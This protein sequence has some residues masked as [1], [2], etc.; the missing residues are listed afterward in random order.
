M[1]SGMTIEQLI[2]AVERAERES[3]LL[4]AVTAPVKVTRYEVSPGVVYAMQFAEPAT[5]VMG[6]A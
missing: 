4:A 1:F 2:K 3:R 6:V 5:A